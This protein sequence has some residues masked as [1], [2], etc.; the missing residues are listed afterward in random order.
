MS[1]YETALILLAWAVAGGNPGPA[2]LA[3][4]GTSM[5]TGRRA[6]LTI[7]SGI[8]AGSATWGIAAALGMS[9]VMMANAWLFEL[10]RYV[11]AFYLLYLA[12]KALRRA[13]KPATAAS[14]TATKGRLFAKGFLLHLTNPKA[15]LAW[16][17]IY[18]IVLPANAA[19]VQAWQLFGQLICVSATVFLGYAMLFSLPALARGYTKARRWFDLVFAAAFGAASLKLLTAKLEF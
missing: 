9:A 15:V 16:G 17:A 10:V 4:S 5:D 12:V 7:A 6:G 2:T 11:G 19:P 8:L 18:A 1:T 3:I 14:L 13:I